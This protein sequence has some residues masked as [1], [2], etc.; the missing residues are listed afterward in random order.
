MRVHVHVPGLVHVPKAQYDAEGKRPL[1]VH[2]AEDPAI[3]DTLLAAVGAA[4]A[5]AAVVAAVVGSW[6]KRG[7]A[8]TAWERAT[9]ECGAGGH[10][11]RGPQP[12]A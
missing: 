2:D 3:A 11:R 12:R 5:G 10:L 8:T 9:S 6:E 7:G 1:E 4:A